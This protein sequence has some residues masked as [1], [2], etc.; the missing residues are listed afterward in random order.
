MFTPPPSPSPTTRPLTEKDVD[1]SEPPQTVDC[2][3]LVVAC[4]KKRTG[5]Y[6]R[7][8][9]ILLPLFAIIC[10]TYFLHRRRTG[11]PPVTGWIMDS[12]FPPPG[13]HL[14]PRHP[15]PQLVAVSPSSRTLIS[16]STSTTSSASGSPIPVSD[17]M[18]PT[19]PSSAPVLPTPFPQAL[20]SGVAQNFSSSTCAAFFANMTSAAPFRTC[21]PFSLLLGTSG[22]FIEVRF[23]QLVPPE[24]KLSNC[25]VEKAQ[26][27]LTLLNS[28]IWGTCNTPTPYEKCKSNMSW[29]AGSL[30]TSCAE[31]LKDRNVMVSNTL[32]GAFFISIFLPLSF[33]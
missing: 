8:A 23:L 20:D 2:P 4:K 15:N 26:T 19:V 29:F 32:V 22:A 7:L 27:N 14:H 18:V 9:T 30:Q 21:R 10:T 1:S 17:Q 24:I 12:A 28:I 13:H 6:F 3:I 31:E 5:R 33:G 11:H 16:T 25:Q